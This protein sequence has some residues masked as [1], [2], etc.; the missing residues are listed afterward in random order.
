[1]DQQA[2]VAIGQAKP[3]APPCDHRFKAPGGGGGIVERKSAIAR[4]V[5]VGRL[6]HECRQGLPPSRL[7]DAVRM[8]EEQPLRSRL[9]RRLGPGRQLPPAPSWRGDRADAMPLGHRHR[10]IGRTAIHNHDR[11]PGGHGGRRNRLKGA[12]ERSGAVQARV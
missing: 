3:P 2:L 6:S 11:P 1:M 9:D 8:Q 4:A 12:V 10:S 5:A 7:R